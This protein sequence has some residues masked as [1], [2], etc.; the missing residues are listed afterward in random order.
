MRRA[1]VPEA[2]SAPAAVSAR[3]TRSATTPPRTQPIPPTAITANVAYA[4]AVP[5]APW[6]SRKKSRIHAHI[7]NSSHM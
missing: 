6:P 2:K 1:H 3:P 5:S 7:A 4:A